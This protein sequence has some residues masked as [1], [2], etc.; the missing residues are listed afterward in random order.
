MTEM[1][2]HIRPEQGNATKFKKFDSVRYVVARQIFQGVALYQVIIFIQGKPGI[3]LFTP[4][5]IDLSEKGTNTKPAQLVACQKLIMP[6][7]KWLVYIT[8]GIPGKERVIKAQIM[9]ICRIHTAIEMVKG[10]DSACF[11]VDKTYY[12]NNKLY[13]T[14]LRDLPGANKEEEVDQLKEMFSKILHL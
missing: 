8:L 4:I 3:V 5:N 1:S 6:C 13:V 14:K 7:R 9:K 2:T 10:G 12:R 11:L